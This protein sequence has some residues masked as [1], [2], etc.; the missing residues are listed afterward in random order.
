MMSQIKRRLEEIKEAEA[1]AK[2]QAQRNEELIDY[3]ESGQYDVDRMEEQ[4]RQHEMFGDDRAY[5]NGTY[6]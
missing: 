6:N 3:H 5:Y 4:Y 1:F 2:Q